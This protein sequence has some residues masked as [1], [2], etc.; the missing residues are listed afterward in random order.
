VALTFDDGPSPATTALLDDLAAARVKATFFVVGD[1]A[2]WF[3]DQLRRE[4]AEGH[5]IGNHTLSH[6]YLGTSTPDQV[7][8]QLLGG[9]DEIAAVTGTRPVLVRPPYGSFGAAVRSFGHPL[10]LWDVD[11]RDW[12]HHDPAQVLSRAAAGLRAGSILLMHDTE[13]QVST[14]S[15]V[16][17]LI[18]TLR[19]AGYTLV[20][21]PE[22]F[23][24]GTLAPGGAYRNRDSATRPAEHPQPWDEAP[25]SSTRDTATAV[26]GTALWEY[27]TGAASG[28]AQAER[29]EDGLR[30]GECR[31][32]RPPRDDATDTPAYALRNLTGHR[33]EMHDRADCGRRSA[34]VAPGE[35]QYGDLRSFRV[36]P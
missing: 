5:V 21:V 2:R 6:P 36:L 35:E 15:A 16:P 1:Q 30:P 33:I 18:R 19:A 10:V 27:A 26:A 31:N 25:A 12:Q 22:L 20:T 28:P 7:H 17:E 8:D 3:P 14:L 4:V 32:T 34:V 13:N 9:E 24:P 23:A 29:V 11:S